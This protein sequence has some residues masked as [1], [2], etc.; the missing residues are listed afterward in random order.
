MNIENLKQ[1]HQLECDHIEAHSKETI[2][3]LRE[4]LEED[5]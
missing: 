2:E 5:S 3:K 1:K 4:I